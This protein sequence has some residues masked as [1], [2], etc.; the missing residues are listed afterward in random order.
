MWVCMYRTECKD[1]EK[2]NPVNTALLALAWVQELQIK[3][4]N[5]KSEESESA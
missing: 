1:N 2:V 5:I 4:V 3:C